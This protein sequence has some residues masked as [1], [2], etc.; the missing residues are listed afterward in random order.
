MTIKIDVI[1]PRTDAEWPPDH[2]L[3]QGKTVLTN[4]QIAK[5]PPGSRFLVCSIKGSERLPP[6]DGDYDVDATCKCGAPLVHRASAPKGLTPIC[7]V[8]WEAI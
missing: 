1:T 2:P 6:A 7:H 4:E 8:C 3:R 5:L